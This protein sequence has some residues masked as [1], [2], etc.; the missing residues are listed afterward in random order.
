MVL[1]FSQAGQDALALGDS[2]CFFVL[3]N[4][5]ISVNPSMCLAKAA[6]PRLV[7]DRLYVGR[8]HYFL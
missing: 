4:V 8:Y 3:V 6:K 7:R 5:F 2:A 1:L